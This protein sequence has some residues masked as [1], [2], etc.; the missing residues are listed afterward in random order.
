MTRRS[1]HSARLPAL[2]AALLALPAG[3]AAAD[4]SN[5]VRTAQHDVTGLEQPAQILVD[6]WGI[7]HIYAA[8]T[9]DLFFMQ[10]YNAT[11]DRLWRI[12]LWR[13]RGLGSSC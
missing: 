2:A 7:P 8:N 6:F 13:K 5:A 3:S 12:D 9:H 1:R 10:A 11:R 4:I